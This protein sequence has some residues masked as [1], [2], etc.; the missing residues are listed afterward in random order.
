MTGQRWPVPRDLAPLAAGEVHLWR[1]DLAPP[2]D[3][4]DALRG[5]LSDEERA[6]ADRFYFEID[7]GRYVVAHAALRTLVARYLN[8]PEFTSEFLVGAHGK[9]FL[10]G[11]GALRFNLA[12]SR[13]LGLIALALDREIGVDL[14]AVDAVTEI[15]EVAGHFFSPP[16]CR[17]LR[18]LAA[19]RRRE[20]FFH[21]WSQ[22][23]AYLKGRG[24]GVTLGLDHFDVAADPAQGAG[25]LEDR[26]DP[27]AT[28]RWRLIGLE[29]GAG[30][31]GALAVEGGAPVLRRFEWMG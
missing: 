1:V 25:L 20:G 8:R 23:E 27:G 24:D 26:R 15:E 16:E 7:R 22:K 3:R 5:L 21:V 29:P 13:E 30:F 9:P 6:R 18:R 11:G 2:P 19:A 31:R 10:P 28:S 17:A 12:H 14:E 4:V